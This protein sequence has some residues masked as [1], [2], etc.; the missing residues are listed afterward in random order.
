MSTDAQDK[1]FPGRPGE[2]FRAFLKLG[3]SAFGGPVAHLGYYQ[4]E[5]VAR[6]KWIDEA[7]Y[8]D[9]VALTQFLPGPAS[10]QT[11]M[12]L[13]WK[14]AGWRGAAAAWTGFTLPSAILMFAFAW[15]VGAAGNLAHAGWVRGL[16]VAAA[17]VVAQA[18]VAMARRLCPDVARASIALAAGCV[19]AAFPASWMQL[20]VIAGGAMA[21]ILVE[22][23]GDSGGGA[24]EPRPVVRRHS[25]LACLALFA[26]LLA[27]LPAAARAW[28]APWLRVADGFYRSGA[29]VFGGGHVV[30][31][32]LQQAT[33]GRG[34]LGQDA[35]LAGYGAAQALPGPLFAFA[36]YLG[37]IVPPGGPAGALLA[38]CAIYLP[39]VLIL[40]A[41]LPQWERLRG[42]PR[43]RS[44]LGGANAAVVG[45]LGAAFYSPICTSAITGGRAAALLL[46][47]YAALQFARLQPWIVVAACAATGAW[48]LA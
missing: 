39:G 43:A 22:K 15:G 26:G 6:R 3:C 5:F 9:L 38:L 44:L 1:P 24:A 30:L 41:A 2:V 7:G 29:L 33:V 32:L 42:A 31:P 23:R 40:F 45:L 19:L 20:A 17:A 4:D 12:A 11:A 21:G 10:S 25:G 37:A 16:K 36:A 13:G 14:R 27:L 28:P 48:A 47:A 46:A 34:W 18:V 8:A 35:F